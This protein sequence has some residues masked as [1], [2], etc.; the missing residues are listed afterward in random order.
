MYSSRRHFRATATQAGLAT[1]PYATTPTRAG[2]SL[3]EA[4]YAVDIGWSRLTDSQQD[5]VLNNADIASLYW[6]GDFN[7]PDPVHFFHDPGHRK[8]HIREAQKE[9]R[10]GV[11]DCGC[12]PRGAELIYR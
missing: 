11:D 7:K 2:N 8:Q 12:Y 5:E 9:Y 1:N 3:H 10:N 6:G 4:G